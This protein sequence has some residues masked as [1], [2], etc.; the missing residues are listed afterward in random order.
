MGMKEVALPE[1]RGKLAKSASTVDTVVI[2]AHCHLGWKC[3][4]WAC[5]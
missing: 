1:I 4:V 2:S 3:L 5:L